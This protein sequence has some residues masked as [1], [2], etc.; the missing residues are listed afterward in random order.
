MPGVLRDKLTSLISSVALRD[1][2]VNSSFAGANT[3]FYRKWGQE[4]SPHCWFRSNV[5]STHRKYYLLGIDTQSFFKEAENSSGQKRQA[6]LSSEHPDKH[7]A[8][9]HCFL[10]PQ[11]TE[12]SVSRVMSTSTPSNL[13]GLASI[14]SFQIL[15]WKI[16]AV[17]VWTVCI[18][19][20]E[21]RTIKNLLKA[22]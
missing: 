11:P 13:S 6:S 18:A 1:K 10:Q 20:T 15:M 21:T 3:K 7:S 2:V 5:H 8:M 19:L 12:P 16:N 14:R 4:S 17:S 22:C 9:V